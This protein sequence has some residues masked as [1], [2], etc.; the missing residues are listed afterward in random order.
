MDN[1]GVNNNTNFDFASIGLA[2][3]QQKAAAKGSTLNKDSFMTLLVAQINNPPDPL[4]P[5]SNT[6]FVTQTAQFS[7]LDSL[8]SMQK[9][10]ADFATKF[11]ADKALEASAI[12]G[13]SVLVPGAMGTLPEQ[14]TMPISV[15]VPVSVP[16][17]S[18]SIQN[19][20]GEVIRQVNLGIQPAGVTNY[21]WDGLLANG[22]RAPAGTYEVIAQGTIGDKAQ[23]F[24]TLMLGKV[25]GVVISKDASDT[26]LNVAGVGKVA[27]SDVQAIQQ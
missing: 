25:E 21:Q 24:S 15:N 3:P 20:Q 6:D 4:N 27:L 22:E 8:Q 17:L 7:S 14:G 19:Q 1:N 16:D 5:K 18:L 10:F 23:Q 13:R 11:T 9:S 2:P 26:M 12:V